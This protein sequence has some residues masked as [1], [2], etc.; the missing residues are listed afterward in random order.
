MSETGGVVVG[1]DG[2]GTAREAVKW[3]VREAVRR[4]VPLRIVYADVFASAAARTDAHQPEYSGTFRTEVRRL[5]TE[6]AEAAALERP[7]AAVR[8]AA[9]PGSPASVLMAESRAAAVVVVGDRGLGGFTGLLAGSVATAV[10]AHAHTTTVVVR[11]SGA[12]NP[13]GPVI[14]GVDGSPQ[15]DA[16]LAHGFE[17]AA[18][19]EVPLH[20]VHTW[21]LV[22]VHAGWLRAGLDAEQI[23]AGEDRL[24]AELL[25]GWSERHPDVEVHRFVERAS[26]AAE[27]LRRAAGARLVVTG[28]RG[29]GGFTGLLLGSTSQ[30]LIHHAPCPVLVART[31]KG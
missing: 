22:G 20:V 7:A 10:A 26:P 19:H 23:R 2:S 14:V 12:G 28:A 16:L 21:H 30:A 13:T 1:I 3:A 9:V 24:M 27:L 29:R 8:T 15:S 5:L 31:P 17:Q 4:G 6:A 11:G 18:A 25:S